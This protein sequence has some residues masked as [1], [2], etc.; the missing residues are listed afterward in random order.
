MGI[1]LKFGKYEAQATLVNMTG[2]DK[3]GIDYLMWARLKKDLPILAYNLSQPDKN[4]GNYL[5]E[6]SSE[7][8]WKK[9]LCPR[10]LILKMT[11]RKY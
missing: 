3:T 9:M 10:S 1:T 8:W 7:L 2:I 6:L 11:A 4:E 5:N